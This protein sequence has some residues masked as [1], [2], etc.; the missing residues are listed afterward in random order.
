MKPHLPLSFFII[1]FFACLLSSKAQEEAQDPRL[2][3]ILAEVATLRDAVFAKQQ[4]RTEKYI[5]DLKA[6]EEKTQSTGNLDKVLQVSEERTAWEAGTPTPTFDPKDETVILGLRKL[7]YYFDKEFATIRDT[8]RMNSEQ[9]RTQIQDKFVSLEK[10]LTTEGK[11][12]QAIE[13]RKLKEQFI[14]GTLGAELA[15]T[16][17]K[18]PVANVMPTAPSKKQVAD[19][20]TFPL[21]EPEG[22]PPLPTE[23]GRIVLIKFPE[24]SENFDDRAV[25]EIE[26][27]DYDDFVALG[28]NMST[29]MIAAIR[30]DGRPICW[31]ASGEKIDPRNVSVVRLWS[32]LGPGVIWVDDQGHVGAMGGIAEFEKDLKD[33][34]KVR[35]FSPTGGLV[36]AI[37]DSGERHLLGTLKEKPNVTRAFHNKESIVSAKFGGTNYIMVLHNDGSVVE[38]LNE[39]LP[40]TLAPPQS[41]TNLLDYGCAVTANGGFI[42][43][44]LRK[45]LAGL[46][47]EL[48][49][50]VVEI[51]SLDGIRNTIQMESGK[52]TVIQRNKL[53]WQ[54]MKEIEPALSDALDVHLT[55]AGIVAIL[56]TS[57]VPR[58]GLWEIDELI[59][60][61]K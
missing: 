7:R 49:E 60:A 29:N 23:K 20:A 30:A 14:A 33:L 42:G 31:K 26:R 5:A 34:G 51:K 57:S 25:K 58:S 40:E 52:W 38:F 10:A 21:P 11:I 19:E 46:I 8:A 18:K 36:F 53:E 54:R 48:G 59:E 55:R 24:A 32:G 41:C 61:R 17:V 35:Y 16:E 44:G 56:P 12:A 15:A 28:E 9:Q 27:D 4:T 45:N 50:K 6:L 43:F 22:F 2:D 47:S 37:D 1:I 13:T 39:K 3:V